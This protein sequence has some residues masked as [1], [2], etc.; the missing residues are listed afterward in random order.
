MQKFDRGRL[1]RVRQVA[2]RGS[3]RRERKLIMIKYEQ[4]L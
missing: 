1:S 4:E 3:R 2:V